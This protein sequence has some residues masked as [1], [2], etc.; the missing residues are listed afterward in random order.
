MNNN[1]INIFISGDFASFYRVRE[2]INE[3][4][5][6]L[7]YNDILPIIKEADIKI[8]NLEVPLL[9]TGIPIAKTG[10]NLKLPIKTIEAIKY[11]SF[12]MVTLAN[13]H[14]MDFGPDG[15]MSTI[16][17]C[18]ENGI[19][20]I[21]AGSNLKEAKE[22]RYFDIKDTRIAFINCCENE[23]STTH[24]AVAGCNPMEEVP[25]Y[26]QIQEAKSNANHVIMIVHGGYEMYEYPSPRMKRLYRWFVDLGVDAV[27]G[28]HTH[29]F[30]GYEIYKGKP[31]VYSLGNFI[32]DD[33]PRNSTWNI[34]AAAFLTINEENIDLK[35][36]PF[37]QGDKVVGIVMFD[38][39]EKKQWLE[40]ERA[41]TEQIQDDNILSNKFNEFVALQGR[42]YRSY[43][44]PNKSRL[45]H[46]AKN[47]GLLPR[48]IRGSKKILLLNI[49]RN[50]AHRDIILDILSREDSKSK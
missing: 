29:C 17:L 41:K 15:L 45:I 8:T 30:S 33:K 26:Y 9:E 35:L 16:K 3:S 13:N 27:I 1:Q 22:I 5:Y 38:E 34:G 6:Q 31:V 42:Q 21:G 44:E 11:A 28:H 2:A 7:L 37:R 32:F 49:I 18:D 14:A 4:N 10:P 46:W 48:R 12:D 50:E 20:Y 39:K 24:G 43:L 40:K 47:R 19:K 25:I 23:W 36:F